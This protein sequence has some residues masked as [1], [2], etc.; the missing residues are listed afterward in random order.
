M[1]RILLSFVAAV[2]LSFTGCDDGGGSSKSDVKQ[3]YG[4]PTKNVFTRMFFSGN[5]G[6]NVKS[7]IGRVVGTTTVSGT[8]YQRY[9]ISHANADNLP[10]NV[11]ATNT[12]LWVTPFPMGDDGKV[13][14]AGGNYH[15]NRIAGT[16]TPTFTIDMKAPIG[17]EQPVD[18]TYTGTLPDVAGTY[19]VAV[20]G[21]YKVVSHDESVA[22]QAGTVN[23]CTHV[24]AAGTL[25]GDGLPAIVK[26]ITL[27]GEFWFHDSFGVVKARIPALGVDWSYEESWDV[28]DVD[29]EYR[30]IKRS[31]VV[32][33]SNPSWELSTDQVNGK[34]D[35]DK[36]THAKMLLEVRWADDE[37]AKN[38]TQPVATHPAVRI[39]FSTAWGTFF[40]Q[41]TESPVSIFHPEDNGKGYKFYYAYVDEAAKNEPGDNGIIYQIRVQTTDPSV[42][43]DIKATGRIYYHTIPVP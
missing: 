40:Y 27:T 36:M 20:Q 42:T 38:S 37:T 15:D 22:T 9:L 19:T 31:G 32:N 16:V 3:P 5:S 8:E 23:Q 6:T 10:D 43:P 41:M 35:A 28:D 11:A 21:T 14:I 39:E 2:L 12:E 13:T 33:D 17:E 29:G 1:K 24:T 4:K 30:T 34:W 7:V 26:D 25:T 18:T